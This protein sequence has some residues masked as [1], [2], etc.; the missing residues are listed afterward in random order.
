MKVLFMAWEIY[1]DSGVLPEFS[2][3]CTGGGLVIKNICE[4]VGRVCESYLF[5]GKCKMPEMD[6]GNIH[7][8]GTDREEE[9][10]DTGL[11]VQEKHLQTMTAAF[12]KALKKIRPDIVNIHGLGVLAKQCIEVCIAK[13][14]PYVYTEH[15]YI[16]MNQKIPGYEKHIEWEKQ[17][18]RIPDLRVIAVGSGMKRKIIQDFPEIPEKNVSV[19]LNGTNFIAQKLQSDLSKKFDLHEKKVLL[20]VGSILDRKNQ[21]QIAN[22][23]RLLP[24]NM[25]EK[26]KILFCGADAIEGAL[27][28]RISELGLQDKLIYAGSLSNREMK[29]YY[30]IADGLIVPSIAEGLSIAMLETMAY[31]LPIIMFSD[32]ECADDLKDEKVICFAEDRSDQGLADAIVEWDQR[33]WDRD[34]IVQYSKYFSMERMAAD[35]IKFYKQS[36]NSLEENE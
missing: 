20:C 27:Q 5:I 2:K 14:I 22:A 10:Q 8:V 12:E 26:I 7:L 35:Y 36:I 16:G 25:Q 17:L 4:Y 3:Y 19:I 24:C 6:L 15:L 30:S 9:V 28:N 34:Y 1:D 11:S 23:F 29:E 33:N 18:F 21:M 31:G 13:G 32:L